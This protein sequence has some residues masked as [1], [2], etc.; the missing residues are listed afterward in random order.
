MKRFSFLKVFKLHLFKDISQSLL[1]KPQFKVTAVV[2]QEKTSILRSEVF[3]VSLVS[4]RME[5]LNG[6]LY[7]SRSTYIVYSSFSTLVSLSLIGFSVEK[8][9]NIL[10][11]A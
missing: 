6:Y 11:K 5:N 8:S 4:K 10:S 1:V 2:L 3:T 9:K 7:L